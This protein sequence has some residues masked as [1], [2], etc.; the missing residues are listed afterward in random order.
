MP[1]RSHNRTDVG[2]NPIPTHPTNTP[3]H[4]ISSNNISSN[5]PHNHHSSS[6]L[7]R[8]EGTTMRRNLRT[9]CRS[10]I[11][12]QTTAAGTEAAQAWAWA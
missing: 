11:H 3:H 9:R 1:Q 8:R 2:L 10:T 12:P 6:T 7:H 4:N 5:N